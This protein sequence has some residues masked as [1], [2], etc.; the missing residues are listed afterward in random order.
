M[1]VNVNVTKSIHVYYM[2]EAIL[3]ISAGNIIYNFQEEIFPLERCHA[4][5][6]V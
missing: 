3:V 5:R 4:A 2:S 6:R 1:H